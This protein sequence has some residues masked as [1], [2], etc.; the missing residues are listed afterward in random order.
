MFSLLAAVM[1]AC[2]LVPN[3]NPD[4]PT[5]TS[6]VV[7]TWYASLKNSNVCPSNEME[8]TVYNADNTG[9]WCFVENG[10]WVEKGFTYETGNHQVTLTFAD[11]TT[12]QMTVSVIS[13]NTMMC[14]DVEANVTW[15]LLKASHNYVMQLLGTWKRT[16]EP[17]NEPN[18]MNDVYTLN[19][20]GTYQVVRAA[21]GETQQ[22]TWK[23]YG[24]VLCLSAEPFLTRTMTSATGY[25]MDMAW[26]TVTDDF[27]PSACA[28]QRMR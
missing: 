28:M 10:V 27:Q 25:T 22:G 2:N 19:A 17:L 15:N 14:K 20:D 23:A 6:K 16:T 5:L 12:R 9:K 7:G 8:V 18:T 1:G 26:Q 11:G 13:A 3:F 4:E 24:C 21:S